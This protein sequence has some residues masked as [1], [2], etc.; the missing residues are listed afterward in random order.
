MIQLL[1]PLVIFFV[2]T[3][4]YQDGDKP[5]HKNHPEVLSIYHL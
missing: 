4:Y 3:V 5:M 1:S 2:E